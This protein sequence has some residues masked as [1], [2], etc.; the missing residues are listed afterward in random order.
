MMDSFHKA[1]F[2]LLFYWVHYPYII[3]GFPVIASGTQT[4][5]NGKC[6]S[7]TFDNSLSDFIF[8]IN[9]KFCALLQ[10]AFLNALCFETDML[11]EDIQSK[12]TLALLMLS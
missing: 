1:Q 10:T 2:L 9:N 8:L 11:H 7:N 6:V 4:L 12:H 5:V 3:S